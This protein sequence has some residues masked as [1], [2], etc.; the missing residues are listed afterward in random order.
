M[1]TNIRSTT[2]NLSERIDIIMIIP[3]LLLRQLLIDSNQHL[4]NIKATGLFYIFPQKE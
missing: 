4:M 3:I 2:I 1:L